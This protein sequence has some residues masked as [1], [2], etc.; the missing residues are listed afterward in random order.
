MKKYIFYVLFFFLFVNNSVKADDIRDFQIEG[1]SVSTSLLEYMT[2]EEIK[3]A[4]E[5][6]T[7]YPNNQYIVIFSNKPSDK[8]DHVEITYDIKDKDY[9]ILSIVGKVLYP[10]NYIGCK[11]K[12]KNIVKIFKST[13]PKS[14]ID[15][16]EETHYHDNKSMVD[17]S[18]F[19]LINGGVARVSCTDW[20]KELGDKFG[21]LDVMK[22]SISNE[23]MVDYLSSL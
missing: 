8:Y 12:K 19:Y 15:Q 20:T 1:M 11:N 10:D 6:S 18:D 23:K 9:S 22:I 13:F 2:K 14:K 4:E 21:W 5:N 17:T 7:L 3:K 16:F